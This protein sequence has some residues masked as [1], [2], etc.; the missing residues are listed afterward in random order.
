MTL[1]TK[2]SHSFNRP[3][4]VLGDQTRSSH[5]R[6]NS[7]PFNAL[8]GP[9]RAVSLFAGH[10]DITLHP[11]PEPYSDAHALAAPV[12][13]YR[14]K[15]QYSIR[16][17]RPNTEFFGTPDS[18]SPE[19]ALGEPREYSGHP[20]TRIGQ[21]VLKLAAIKERMELLEAANGRLQHRIESYRTD[22]E[23]LSSSVTYF[24]S[25]YY[26]GLLTIRD[27]RARSQQDAEIMSK[28]EQQLFQ[29]KKFVGLMVEIGLHEP[30]LDRAHQSVLAGKDFEPVLVE[31]IR[32][33][34]VRRGSAWSSILS[35]VDVHAP[36]PSVVFSDA[37]DVIV[38]TDATDVFEE[39]RQSTVDNLLKDLKDGNIPFG[40]HRSA[41]QRLSNSSAR[42][43]STS[44]GTLRV[45]SPMGSGALLSPGSPARCVLGKLD[46]NR[47]P[48][49]RTRQRS[50]RTGKTVPR[51]LSSAAGLAYTAD[52][53]PP[54]GSV[55]DDLSLSHQRALASLQRLLD[56]FSSG[57][58]GS[59]GTTT[60]GTQSADCDSDYSE[61]AQVYRPPLSTAPSP[62][63]ARSP[64]RGCMRPP[65]ALDCCCAVVS[66]EAHGIWKLGVCVAE[67]AM[68]PHFRLWNA[69]RESEEKGGGGV[70]VAFVVQRGDSLNPF[71]PILARNRYVNHTLAVTPTSSGERAN[72]HHRFPPTPCLPAL[73]LVVLRT[74]KVAIVATCCKTLL[75]CVSFTLI[76]PSRPSSRCRPLFEMYS[77]T[78]LA[79][80]A[81]ALPGLL[82]ATPV[83]T[84][85]RAV[86]FIN[87]TTNG[88]SWLD[89]SAGLG[90]PLNVV[91]SAQSSP[92]V[93]TLDGFLQYAQTI[94][95]DVE[96]LGLHIGN[97]Q[98][99]NL[100]DGRGDVNETE[101][102]RQSFGIPGIGTCLESLEGE[103]TSEYSP[104]VSTG[105]IF[106][107]VSKEEDASESHNIVPDGY[108]IGRDL[109]V[110]GAVGKK[111]GFDGKKFK[112]TTYNTVLT[113]LT[114]LIAP[115][116]DG[117]NH[118]I[119]QDGVI[120]LL[121]V[122]IV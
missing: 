96:C 113:N 51:T 14:S 42:K 90:E 29:L 74:A 64:A 33:A 52:K 7:E 101:V 117:V 35:A 87:P 89:K 85:K 25:E 17:P 121:T 4:F 55:G 5:R 75:P 112:F 63:M 46:V 88:G 109:L 114:G 24:S 115:G 110:A 15:L 6:Y 99:A 111:T 94:G 103:T 104:Q 61:R 116:S 43:R 53:A 13:L 80:L 108:N 71:C 66:E 106:L 84:T 98:S 83:T 28:Q 118:G 49:R 19:I 37:P 58:F 41:S 69:D 79:V 48:P 65:T 22:A 82:S 9:R 32:N 1:E 39:R 97:P 36:P 102:L 67:Q 31:A 60:D 81:L 3:S 50:D 92:E 47:S 10:G 70:S 11:V 62:P 95:F 38:P 68:S 91:I 40:R 119:A 56:N 72:N 20:K 18:H 34:A 27:L 105:A 45:K 26:A 76:S 54:L 30:V 2:A 107:A 120:K 122:T 16:R 12:S 100:G 21:P 93:L 59:L 44:N 73:N 78:V 8:L 23:M 77:S 86:D 57:S